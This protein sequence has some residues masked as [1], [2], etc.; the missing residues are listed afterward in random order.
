MAA[1]VGTKAAVA[2]KATGNIAGLLSDVTAF[3]ANDERVIADED[4]T[5]LVSK[6]EELMPEVNAAAVVAD[7]R[8]NRLKRLLGVHVRTLSAHP[9]TVLL[10]VLVRVSNVVV[11]HRDIIVLVL[12]DVVNNFH[13]DNIVQSATAVK[14]D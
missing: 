7:Q 2:A 5:G 13:L 9:V 3:A 14:D 10:H 11:K 4:T 6:P 1:V 12:V 8:V